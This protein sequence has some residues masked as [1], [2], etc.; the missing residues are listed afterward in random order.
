MKFK[1]LAS[2]LFCLFISSGYADCPLAHTHI[3]V[4]P[5]WRPDWSA[6]SS[7]ELAEDT[8]SADNNKLWFFS[9]PPSHPKAS[10]PG[11]PQWSNADGSTFLRLTPVMDGGSPVMKGG[12]S[13]KQ[14][15]SSSFMYS[16]AGGYGDPGG[17]Q[18][19]DGWHSAHGPQG[20][21]NLDSVNQ[22]ITP[23]WDIFLKREDTSVASEDFFMLLPNDTP[24]LMED[25][26]SY[27][28]SKKWLDEKNAWGIH[29]HMTF[30]FWLTPEMGQEVTATFSAY[31]EGGLYSASDDYEF[32]FVTVP[33]PISLSF[34]SAGGMWLLRRRR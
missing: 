26:D 1:I 4:N 14:L 12:S 7:S 30:N 11:W 32:S 22:N 24:A 15:W 23:E 19:L 2:F 17:V 6:P 31:D 29:D 34:I 13:G 16:E 9:L 20:K 18:H 10:T 27:Q 8:N 5:T 3:G 25:G 21:W 28:L 33:E